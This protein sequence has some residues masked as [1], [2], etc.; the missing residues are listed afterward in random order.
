MN[1]AIEREFNPRVSVPDT[2]P[3]IQRGARQS[4]DAYARYPHQANLKYGPGELATLDYFAAGAPNKPLFV[5]IHGGFWR[6][7]D[8][9]DFAYVANSIVPLG[10][11]VAL[12]NY[13]LCPKVTVAQIVQQIRDGLIWLDAQSNKLGFTPGLLVAGHSA[14]A[15]LLATT[16]AKTGQ[17]YELPDNIVKKA[18]L[19]SGIYECTPVLDISVNAEIQM[20]PEDVA[21]M[22]PMRFKMSPHVVYEVSAGG[23]EPAGWVK[24][25]SDFAKH[26]EKL[27]CRVNTHI[28]PELNHYSI[29]QEFEESTG[30]SPQLIKND[31][32]T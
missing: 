13:D 10:C 9:S 18:Y 15:H 23:A 31:L 21:A 26:L 19:I 6:G 24:Q 2:E 1:E 14:G 22:S 12:M 11:N 32:G 30:Y 29:M 8:K 20:K 5:F 17:T 3:Y 4:A 16:L 25:S 27:G 7:R 28:R